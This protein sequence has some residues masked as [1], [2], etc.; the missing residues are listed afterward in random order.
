[1]PLLSI[2]KLQ[3]LMILSEDLHDRNGRL[4]VVKGTVLTEKHF[5]VFKTW[6]IKE[7]G[8]IDGENNASE[9]KSPPNKIAEQIDATIEELKPLFCHTNFDHPFII[10]LLHLIAKKKVMNNDS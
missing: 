8:I 2:A 1:M 4:L 9:E 5:L 10:E 7:V 3:P 6:G